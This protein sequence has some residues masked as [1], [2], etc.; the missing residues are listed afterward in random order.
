M[1]CLFCK[2]IKGEIPSK[3]IYEDDLVKAFYDIEPKAPVHFLIIPKV[4]IGSADEINAQNSAVVAHVYET[5]A[6]LAREMKLDG[7]Y[8]IVCNCGD[9]AGQTVHHL[10]F[11]VLGG[12]K[13]SVDM[14]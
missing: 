4:H 14:A 9:D 3:T 6:K 7:G 13:L 10:H 5:A 11:H 2:I 12:K 1:D 8:R